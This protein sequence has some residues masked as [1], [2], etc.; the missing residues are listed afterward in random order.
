MNSLIF[1]L[2]LYSLKIATLERI[3]LNKACSSLRFTPEPL[4]PFP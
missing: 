1:Y 4:T 2:I 3:E